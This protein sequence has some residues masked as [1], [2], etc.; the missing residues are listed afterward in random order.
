MVVSVFGSSAV[1]RMYFVEVCCELLSWDVGYRR[2]N[3]TLGALMQLGPAAFRGDKLSS[4]FSVA[5]IA[6]EQANGAG[7]QRG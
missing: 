3:L 2:C 7:Q 5:Q 4:R 1:W 6:E